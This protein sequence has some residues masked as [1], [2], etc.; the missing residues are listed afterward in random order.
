[1][2]RHDTVL[3]L[4][5]QLARAVARILGRVERMDPDCDPTELDRSLEDL[6]GVSLS[7]LR[8]LPVDQL[9]EALLSGSA[10]DAVRT[11]GAAEA[12]YLDARIAERTCRTESE[13]VRS[14]FKALALYA[15]ALPKL[16]DVVDASTRGRADE[17]LEAVAEWQMPAEVGVRVLTWLEVEGAYARAEDLLYELVDQGSGRIVVDHGLEFYGR[18]LSFPDA[19]LE[20]G[21]LPRDEVVAGLRELEDR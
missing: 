12:L 14:R 13:A 5:Q 6:T 19:Q 7:L 15:E 21:G 11:L 3:R 16:G 17:L 8:T 4:I 1:M 2:L 9:S 20:A 18:L 10:S